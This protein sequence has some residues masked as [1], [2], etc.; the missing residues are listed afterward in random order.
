MARTMDFDFSYIAAPMVGASDL[1]YR[2][3]VRNYG[4]T[5]VYTQMLRPER[6]LNDQEYREFHQRSLTYDTRPV[7]VQL[8]GNDPD[9]VVKA[10]R[11][12]EGLCDAIGTF[13]PLLV[14]CLELYRP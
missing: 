4:A 13:L 14:G 5:L 1:P 2:Q 3:L 7:V 10:G 11:T 8:C 6:L 9:M 12:V